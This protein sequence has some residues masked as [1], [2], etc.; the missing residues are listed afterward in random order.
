[1]SKV[2]KVATAMTVK[3]DEARAVGSW[4]LKAETAPLTAKDSGTVLGMYSRDRGM[5]TEEA[6]RAFGSNDIDGI[7]IID[8]I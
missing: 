8:S 4:A 7:V 6:V 5:P 2:T 3:I 1:M